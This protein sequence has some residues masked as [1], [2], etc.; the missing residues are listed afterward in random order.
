MKLENYFVDMMAYREGGKIYYKSR[1][2]I[3]KDFREVL[4][5][6]TIFGMKITRVS[7]SGRIRLCAL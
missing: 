4:I 1:G 7:L 3:I 2:E 5:E 6:I